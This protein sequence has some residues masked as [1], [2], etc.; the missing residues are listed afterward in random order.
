MAE[1]GAGERHLADITLIVAAAAAADAA[2]GEG[3][4]GGGGDGLPICID[5]FTSVLDRRA[6]A[7][8]CG[9][10][11]G[12]LAA[13]GAARRP[14]LV[15]TV[16]DDI[17][18]AL[19]PDNLVCTAHR[20]L[21]ALEWPS[22]AAAAADDADADDADDH[23]AAALF[24]PPQLSFE[25]RTVGSGAR[26]KEL[27][28][29]TFQMHHYMSSALLDNA[30][31]DV[32]RLAPSREIVGFIATA[33]QPGIHEPGKSC[34][35]SRPVRR[36]HRL[37]VLPRWQGCAIGPRLSDLSAAMDGD[38][39]NESGRVLAA[40]DSRNFR[41]MCRTSHPRFGLY[42]EQRSLFRNEQS[43]V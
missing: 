2:A 42:R 6:A 22:P 19:R 9:G 32:L 39:R 36:E 4:G 40:P 33:S 41:Y 20:R 15:A 10:V 5:E 38:A 28:R 27:W 18:R 34:A 3:G 43:Y 26:M 21:H 16:H 8:V 30:V 12:W 29:E 25:L 23:E 13:C 11:R 37:V 31:A 7:R 35:D 1:L 24:A 17:L 14:L